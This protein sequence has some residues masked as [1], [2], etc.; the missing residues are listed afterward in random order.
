MYT[1]SILNLCDFSAMKKV[2]V[3]WARSP[4]DLVIK[5]DHEIEMHVLH[6]NLR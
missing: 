2:A 3:F 4:I 5:I 1:F 6:T